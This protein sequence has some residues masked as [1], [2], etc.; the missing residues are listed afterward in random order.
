[1][2]RDGFEAF[3]IWCIIIFNIYS[4][5]MACTL[6]CTILTN[7]ASLFCFKIKDRYWLS[8]TICLFG[9]IS[10]IIKNPHI[11]SFKNGSSIHLKYTMKWPCPVCNGSLVRDRTWNLQ[12]SHKTWKIFRYIWYRASVKQLI[13]CKENW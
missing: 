6:H 5:F 10:G 12:V 8:F 7:L 3:V 13:I 11:V 9:I 4:C 1:M 2:L